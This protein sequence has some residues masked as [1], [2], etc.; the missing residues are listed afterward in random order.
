MSVK[1]LKAKS[2]TELTEKLN[3][4][5]KS[6]FDLRMAKGNGQLSKVHVI[7]EIRRDI[8]RVRTIIRQNELE[9][10]KAGNK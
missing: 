8:A 1:D 10:N 9:T 6:Q 4:L 2:S 5:L 7:K 3:E